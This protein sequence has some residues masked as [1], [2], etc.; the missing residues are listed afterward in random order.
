MKFNLKVFKKGKP[1]YWVL[2]GLAIFFIFYMLFSRGGG[3]GG[4]ATVVGSGPSEAMQIA[5]MNAAAQTQALQAQVNMAANES[6]AGIAIANLQANVALAELQAGR[7]VSMAN[8]NQN[9]V[10]TMAGYDYQKQIAGWNFEYSLESARVAADTSLKAKGMD[11]ALLM[12]QMNVNQEMFETQSNN[13]IT[14]SVIGQIGNLKKKDRDEAFSA[15]LKTTMVDSG[16]YT[17]RF[18]SI[19]YQ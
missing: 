2:G 4:S 13:L 15:V 19:S 18:G 9:A 1:I 3:G 14:Q 17:D 6:A 8:I 16:T 7:E 12:H 5:S 11:T 10:L